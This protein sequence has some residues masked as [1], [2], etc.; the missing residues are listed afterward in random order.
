[1]IGRLTR[2]QRMRRLPASFSLQFMP[3]LQLIRV[4]YACF[5]KAIDLE[6]L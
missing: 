2:M 6:E 5:A 4:P 1:M 3:R